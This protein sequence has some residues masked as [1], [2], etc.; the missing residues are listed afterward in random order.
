[1]ETETDVV[2]TS[3]SEVGP[4]TV[5]ITFETP[6]GFSAA[7]GQ[8]VRLDGTVDS[9]TYRRFYT[10]SSPDTD[11]TFEVTVEVDKA[12]G[13]PFSPYLAGLEVGD[14]IGM[15]GPFGSAHYEGERRVVVLAGGPGVGPAVG[16]GERARREGGEVAI[17]YRDET[18]AHRERLDRLREEGATVVVTDEEI[19]GHVADIVTGTAAEQVFVYGFDPFVTAALAAIERAGG[20]PDAAK[21]E[22]FE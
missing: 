13:G 5:A 10:L 9:E 20:D 12:A 22:S 17:V 21:V 3:V 16:L 14:E 11:G 4:D 2:V 6:A 1:M 8:F 15:A 7:P 19:D 18:P